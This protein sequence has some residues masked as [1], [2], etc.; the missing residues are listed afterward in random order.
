MRVD[1]ARDRLGVVCARAA[2]HSAE[3]RVASQPDVLAHAERE[4]RLLALRDDGDAPR[5]LAAPSALAIVARRSRRARRERHLPVQRAHERALAAAVRTDDGG[6]PSARRV[7]R[8]AVD[9]A[10]ARAAVADAR[11][12]RRRSRE[13]PQPHE[14][15]RHADAAP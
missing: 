9:R 5:E 10:L 6:Q 3:V 13:P 8:H 11:R 2:R 14:K 15:E 4:R 1:R 12:R 7:E